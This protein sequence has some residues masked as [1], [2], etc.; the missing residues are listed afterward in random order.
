MNINHFFHLFSIIDIL[1]QTA[2]YFNHN[3]KHSNK[4]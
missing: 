4:R 3:G 1:K 2:I